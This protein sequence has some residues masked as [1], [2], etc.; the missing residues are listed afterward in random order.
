MKVFL[1]GSNGFLGAHL[2][3]QL[4]VEKIY[5]VGRLL[6]E[7]RHAKAHDLI[8]RKGQIYVPESARKFIDDVE[9]LIHAGG[10]T[11]KEPS[12]ANNLQQCHESLQITRALTSEMFPNLKK[13]IFLS[14]AD[15]YT[16]HS[17]QID[18]LSETE[19]RN[20]YVA[21]KLL[22]EM[23]IAETS[24]S[25]NIGFE[26]FRLGHIFGPGDESYKK[27]LQNLVRSIRYQTP[28][29]LRTSLD[30]GLNL[31][32][33]K[34]A[35]DVIMQSVCASNSAGITNLVSTKSLSLQGLIGTLESLTGKRIDLVNE[36]GEFH[37]FQY[38]FD[39]AKLLKHFAI[40][41]TPLEFALIK[42]LQAK[43]TLG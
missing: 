9:I 31:L 18:E 10:Y 14:T 19:F 26:I 39:C 20:A 41:E 42:T 16:R 5:S 7:N 32:Y 27:V 30:Q 13:V 23:I 36:F 40:V 12:E 17:A 25:K 8:R 3:H 28:F 1:T 24:Q 29:I 11:P 15:V 6:S 35:V 34:D 33:V 38:M 22:G 37:T 43:S 2:Y 4:S 21:S